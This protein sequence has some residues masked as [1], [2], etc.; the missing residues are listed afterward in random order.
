MNKQGKIWGTT[1]LL[2]CQNNIQVHRLEIKAGGYCSQHKHVV[3]YNKFYVESGEITIEVWNEHASH[4]DE[5]HLCAGECSTIEP[6]EYHRFTADKDSVVYEM[7][8]VELWSDDIVR[9]AVGGIVD[10]K[11]HD[12]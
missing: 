1:E 4:V 10:G 9:E 6:G 11:N 3:K 7:Y 2:F 12:G 8:W 5:T